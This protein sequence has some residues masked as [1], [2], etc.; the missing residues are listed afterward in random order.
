MKLHTLGQLVLLSMGSQISYAEMEEEMDNAGSKTT[1]GKVKHVPPKSFKQMTSQEY[2][3]YL[4]AV[5]P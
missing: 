1:P 2:M 4:D 5:E 3:A